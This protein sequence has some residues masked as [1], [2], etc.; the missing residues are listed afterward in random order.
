MTGFGRRVVA[1]VGRRGAVLLIFAFIDGVVAWSLID[2]QSR[3]QV[4]RLATYR[5]LVDVAPLVVWAWLWA[6]AGVVLAVQAFSRSDRW[7]YAVALG[8]KAV[9]AAGLGASWLV[10]GAPR[11]WLAAATWAVLAALVLVISGWHEPGGGR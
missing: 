3:S 6:G 2:P 5:A 9:W 10:Y 8:I 4:G 1:R 11:A 7:G